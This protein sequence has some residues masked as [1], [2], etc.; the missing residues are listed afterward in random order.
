MLVLRASVNSSGFRDQV[1]VRTSPYLTAYAL[2]VSGLGGAKVL[3]AKDHVS[4]VNGG[5]LAFA[6]NPSRVRA[7]FNYNYMGIP[8]KV[9]SSNWAVW[10]F[11][12]GYHL[13]NHRYSIHYSQRLYYHTVAKPS[14][15]WP[16]LGQNKRV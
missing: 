11:L 9:T 5:C 1:T 8:R 4:K 14:G 6:G 12:P 10:S 16:N 7:D 2:V 13:S 3:N 15:P